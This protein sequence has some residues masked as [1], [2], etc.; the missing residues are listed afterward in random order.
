[1]EIALSPISRAYR[2]SECLLFNQAIAQATCKF[3]QREVAFCD[4]YHFVPWNSWR[5]EVSDEISL[6]EIYKARVFERL[7]QVEGWRIML[8]D[9]VEI[10]G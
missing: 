1:M 6:Q 9:L 2:T 10:S 5:S 3:E 4:S 7:G 8:I